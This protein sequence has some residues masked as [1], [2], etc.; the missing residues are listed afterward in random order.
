[1]EYS[2]DLQNEQ[3]VD[4]L[5][6]FSYYFLIIGYCVKIF[7]YHKER[8]RCYYPCL[9]IINTTI[10]L[11]DNSFCFEIIQNQDILFQVQELLPL[12]HIL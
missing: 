8:Q 3:K 1:M 7:C 11:V 4:L 9:S 10:V 2:P 5:R 12:L 6:N